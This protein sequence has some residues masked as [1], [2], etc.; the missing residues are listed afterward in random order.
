MTTATQTGREREV[1]NSWE[2][3]LEHVKSR[4]SINTYTTWFQP[5]RLNRAEGETLYVQIPSAVFRQVLTRTYGDIVKAV[6]HELGTPN[7]KVQYV[8][9]E[10]EPAPAAPTAPSRPGKSKLDFESSDHQLNTRY[11]FDTFVVGK[12]N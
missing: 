8:C 4:V 12:S 10:E 11:T 7:V 3:F 2:K 9:T 1:A 6:F 5:T